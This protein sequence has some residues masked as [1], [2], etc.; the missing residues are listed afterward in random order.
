MLSHVLELH[1]AGA[2]VPVSPL[3]T[4]NMSELQNAMR[5]MQAGKHMGKVV[6]TAGG[7]DIVQ[8]SVSSLIALQSLTYCRSCQQ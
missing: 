6:I 3:M 1:Q 7:G 5:L 2:M 8:V 4:Y